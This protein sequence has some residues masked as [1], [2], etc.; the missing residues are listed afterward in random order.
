V[1]VETL[2][3]PER[4]MLYPPWT[5]GDSKEAQGHFPKLQA[6]SPPHPQITLLGM[7]RIWSLVMSNMRVAYPKD[8]GSTRKACPRHLHN[9]RE[10]TWNWRNQDSALGLRAR[11]L[12][13]PRA[14][15]SRNHSPHGLGKPAPASAIWGN[16]RHQKAASLAVDRSELQCS[17]VQMTR[18]QV[19][20]QQG[21]AQLHQTDRQARAE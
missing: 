6:S 16:P 9:P 10:V 15:P 3:G 13:S 2:S 19:L 11:L 12:H 14:N 20:D 5:P 7:P 21:W 4:T 1:L 18:A 17:P 8:T